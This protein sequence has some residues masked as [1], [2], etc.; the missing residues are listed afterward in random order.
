MSP[1][2]ITAL[3][4]FAITYILMLAFQKIRPYVT[5]GS[6]LIFVALGIIATVNPTLFGE[7]FF[8]VGS[9]TFEYS[10][11][12][13]LSEID[14]NVI[15]MIAGTMGTVYLF[16]ESKMP[17]LMS[18]VLI[19]KMPNVKWVVVALSLFAG[20]V[21]AFVD[22]VATVLMIAPVA[23]AFCKKLGISPVPSIICIAVSSNLQG[24][25]TLVGDTTSILLAKAANLDFSDFF[26]HDGHVGMFWVV[27]AGAIV[28]AMIILFMFRKDKE[29]IEFSGRTKVEDKFPTF[30]LVGTV[31]SLIAVSF[32]PYKDAANGGFYKPDI[33]NGIIC[34]AFFL[35]GIIRELLIKKNKD[36]VKNAFK[37]IDYYTIV[38]LTGLFVVI[39]GIKSAGVIDVIGDAIASLGAGSP[40]LV[41]TI[42]VWMSVILSAFIDNIPYTATMLSIVPVI[43]AGV[44][45]NPTV[46]YY[47][48]LCGA[49][50][51]GNL[52]PIGASANIT[53]IGI[54]RKE[55]YEVKAT[56]FMKYGVPFTL[57]AVITGYLLIWLIWGA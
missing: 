30:L 57:S 35:V 42:I 11:A 23:L 49:T 38:L 10:I 3:I 19:S 31:L 4:I 1:I 29:K 22:N 26:V 12:S 55:G 25:A 39:G 51:G 2:T 56:T 40:F 37:E 8:T 54:L 17:Q 20:I 15:M 33:T 48:L 9:G 21:S 16:I 5:V 41:Y 44:G 18:D 24:A 6:A 34:I 14:W 47:G 32:I 28:S 43:A 7:G 52:T 13:A 46:L 45:M 53:G 50:L 36:I 27:Q